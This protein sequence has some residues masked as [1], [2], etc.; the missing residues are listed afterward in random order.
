VGR[1]AGADVVLIVVAVAIVEGDT[2]RSAFL[3]VF[4]HG[5]AARMSV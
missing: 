3:V 5:S 2:A 4:G 1:V